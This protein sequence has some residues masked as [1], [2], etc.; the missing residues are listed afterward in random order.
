MR[1]E[2]L[3]VF[4]Q[5]F[6]FVFFLLFVC[7]FICAALDVDSA[8]ALPSDESYRRSTEQIKKAVNLINMGAYKD[9]EN[10]LLN[11]VA[12]NLW[13]EKAYFLLGRLYKEQGALDK[14]ED[15]LKKA[16]T[17][18]SLLKDYALKTLVDIYIAN[19][20]FDKAIETARQVRNNVLL[21]KARQSEIRA[22][23]ELKKEEEAVKVLHQ[24]IKVYSEDWDSK[25]VLAKLLKNKNGRKKAIKILKDLYIK[26]VPIAADALK[27]LKAMNADT[28]TQEEML[29]RAE[30]LFAKGDFQRAEVI[31][32]KT[33]KDIDNSAMKDKIMFAIGMCQF[34][35]KQYNMAAK[36]FG[37]IKGP[38]AM[39]WRARALYRADDMDRFNITIKSFQKKY[40]RNKYLAK[41]F[42]MLANDYKR[43][44][45]MREA[46]KI[47]NKV[48][49]DFPKNAEDALWGLGW[50]NY[51][52]GD[53]KKAT[54][55]FSKLTSF[56]KNDRYY[57]Y[58]Y[59]RAKSRGMLAKEC[60][61]RKTDINSVRADSDAEGK[62][63][64]KEDDGTYSRLS[65][66]AGYYGF[67]SRRRLAGRKTSDKI[68]ISR[69]KIPEGEVYKRIE[70]LK[71]LGMK[72]E[73]ID[74]IKMA[75]KFTKNPREFRYLGYTAI[76][77]GEYK[78]ILFFVEESN[79]REFLPLAYPLGYWDFVKE[80]AKNE[81]L[82]AYLIVALIR[83]ESRFDPEALSIAGAVGLMQLMPSTAHR[84]KKDIK[85][86][87]RD[88]S[89]LYDVRKNIFIGAHYLSLLI[90][91]FK[92]I[93]LAIA[94]YNAGEN[95]VKKW[96][97]DSNHKD[98]EEFIEDI[99]YRETKRYVKKVLRS[100]WQYRTI[101]GLPI[102][103][104]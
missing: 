53:Y 75:L 101:N 3:K 58:L 42:L 98:I 10:I 7:P 41:L 91:E 43:A 84:I 23:L 19:E 100:Y 22:L 27:E 33:L 66:D 103:E 76:D 104:Y 1:I 54:K 29:K 65:E 59:W 86:K 20:K 14:A 26:A 82:D 97:V 2:K 17:Q 5:V 6:S 88:D 52:A 71:F 90:K 25:L 49:N 92:E 78:S 57:K 74:E 56:V 79:N 61:M 93:P 87:L 30:N 12:D 35:Q 28:F 85:I 55:Y 70:A 46:E 18:Y 24:Y 99:P 13:Q 34:K 63:C 8:S 37:V 89:E 45:N 38:K 47:F 15:Y 95:A 51:T 96:L 62:G 39:Y 60:M 31:Y 83:E 73:A 44:G 50:M 21:Q 64:S 40:P 69:P 16:A 4:I 68:E 32:K 102:E 94:A 81:A 48:L 11:F 9:A 80:V 67:L 36:S 77:I 72:S